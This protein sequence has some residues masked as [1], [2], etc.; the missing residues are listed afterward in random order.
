M[1]NLYTKISQYQRGYKN[2]LNQLIT[3]RK[4]NMFFRVKELNQLYAQFLPSHSYVTKESEF[5]SFL[6][7]IFQTIPLK[8]YST[9][10][11]IVT[12]IKKQVES[13]R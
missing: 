2:V 9:H 13:L 7:T 3:I 4:N 6:Q 8:N 12:Y 1:N 5:L 11:D 10:Q